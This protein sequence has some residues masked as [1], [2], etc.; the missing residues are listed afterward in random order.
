MGELSLAWRFARRELRSGLSGFRIFL[1]CLA[2][3]VAALA[4]VGTISADLLNGLQRDARNLLGGE[5]EL[6]LFN[7]DLTAEESAWL[8]ENSQ[9]LSAIAELRAMASV[10]ETGERR[11][12]ELKAVD[13]AYPLYGQVALTPPQSVPDG[14]AFRDGQWGVLAAP[15]LYRRLDLQIGDEI[16][17]GTLRFQLRGEIDSEPDS[18]ARAI[19]LGPRVLL[20]LEALA[21]TGLAQPG[22]LVYRHWRL[23]LP[24]GEPFVDWTERLGAAFPDAGW[25]VRGLDEAAPSVARFVGQVRLFMTLVG[26]TA[27]VVGGVGVANAVRAHLE[28]RRDTIAALKCLGASAGL[29]V[30]LYLVQVLLLASAGIAVGLLVGGLAPV[31]AAPFLSDLFNISLGGPPD[32]V[33]LARAAA[34]GYLTA[35]LFA[36]IPLARAQS[37]PA[38]GLFRGYVD[39]RKLRAPLWLWPALVV[40]AAALI[41]IAVVGSDNPIFALG[42]VGAAAAALLLFRLAAGLVV[43]VARRLPRPRH[44]TLRLALSNLHRP[45]APTV[46]IVL[47]LG[48]GL[49]V[50]SAVTLIQ[51]NLSQQVSEELP[52]DAPTFY[53]IDIQNEQTAAFDE[54]VGSFPEASLSERV[55]MLR[56]RITAVDGTPVPELEIP[57]EVAWIF[58]GDRG[59]TWAEQ[60]YPDMTL[61][62]GDW[63]PADYRG[64]TKLSLG[65]EIARE[66]GLGVGDTLTVN[67]YG[68]DVTA[69]IAN[70][71]IIDWA[72]L[73]I[74]FVM[75]FS[76]GLLDQAPASHIATVRIPEAGEAA[77]ADAVA[78]AFPNVTGVR[79]REA[80]ESF[81][82][83]LDSVA[84]AVGITGGITLLA[85]LLVLAGAIAAGERRRR[86]DS[87]V[88]KVLGAT[89][90]VLA[91]GLALEFLLLG[92]ITA[93]IAA[94]VGSLAGWVVIDLV[95]QADFTWLV[96]PLFITLGAGLLLTLFFGMLGT[97]RALGSAAAP[98]LRNE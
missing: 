26:L 86:Y 37:L 71:R 31:I 38:A 32:L 5:A 53:F 29:I 74:N 36:L 4:G 58:E 77:L 44:T 30:K 20:P 95:M 80:L 43:W 18:G 69:E 56:G 9:A 55:P 84:L 48:L 10:P 66:M 70:L 27:L 14:L 52:Q 92:L 79:V 23:V 15:E 59:L 65:D 33:A 47:S 91:G 42:F 63:W 72:S 19:T 11:L 12:I 67:V 81:S 73:R 54:L 51:A 40:T 62:E 1:A 96:E 2:V 50:L 97:W 13:N 49:T 94:L 16:Q 75:I 87:V 98:L 22:S 88:L 7:R 21:E 85:G 82:R 39:T 24:E 45:G 46:S 35:L 64:A 68:R 93:L 17:I 60:P 89:R 3:G 6:R 41:A 8:R 61:T 28:Q 25:R 76:P 34:M 57:E 78:D 90:N 83:M